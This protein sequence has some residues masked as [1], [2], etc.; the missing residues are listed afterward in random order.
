MIQKNSRLLFWSVFLCITVFNV[1]VY[2]N[3]QNGLG[4]VISLTDTELQN[5]I[6][7]LHEHIWKYFVHHETNLIYDY[8][9][10]LHEKNRWKHLP[11]VEEI[12]A[13]KPN[14]AGWGTGMEDC[15]LNG[16]AYLT[17]MVYRYAVTGKMEHAEEARK[18]YLGLQQLGT[19]SGQRGFVA[20]AFLPDGKSHYPN[21][22]ADQYTLYVFGL[23]TYYH[24]DIASELEKKQ[25]QTIIHDICTR[26][27]NDNFEIL[28]SDH[29]TALYC[30]IAAIS[31]DRSSRI[32]EI[33]LIGYD[34]TNEKH[35]LDIY[36]EKLNENEYARCKEI[37]NPSGLKK[38]LTYSILQNQV[39]LIALFE[40]ESMIP[41]QACYLIAIETNAKVVENRVISFKNYSVEI[42]SDNYSLGGWRI[43]QE[44][45]PAEMIKEYH[46]VRVPSE[47]M[48]I[49]LLANNKYLFEPFMGEQDEQ[50][51]E[52]L[53]NNCRELLSTYDYEKMR[54]FGFIYAE[55]VYWLAVKQNLFEY[56][57]E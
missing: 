1:K 33:F 24:S 57:P 30:D 40:L 18:I 21:S 9:A 4:T 22:S 48:F 8:I 17:G 44:P 37:M 14:L 46:L 52:Y 2:A 55:I 12:N 54:T 15:A 35:W 43:G 49:Q 36:I 31:P 47:A 20:R 13:G 6:T 41:I 19:I 3:S 42:H 7:G 25:I 28:S 11:T 32:L 53:R 51:T 23:W 10:P 50:Y 26:I 45:R 16:G 27:E 5:K 29:K 39:S 38:Y 56:T 34:L